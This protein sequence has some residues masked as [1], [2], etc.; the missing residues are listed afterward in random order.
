MSWQ[1]VVS[2]SAKSQIQELAKVDT[3]LAKPVTLGL[4]IEHQATG[5]SP[6]EILFISHHNMLEIFQTQSIRR[7]C[8]RKLAIFTEHHL[9]QAL[10]DL[11]QPILG[12]DLEAMMVR[13][14]SGNFSV[15]KMLI[16]LAFSL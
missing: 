7:Q 13:I 1:A 11:H 12:S 3:P 9:L 16:I 6:Y 8:L 4:G 2:K 10:A 5:W 14:C 15:Q